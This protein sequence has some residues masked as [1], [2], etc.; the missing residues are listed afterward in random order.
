[1]PDGLGY[2]WQMFVDLKN[3]GG[4]SFTEMAAYSE[5]T[6][7]CLTPYEVEFIRRLDEAHKRNQT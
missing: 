5:L 4:C 2:I 6:G 7:D 3:A 1:M